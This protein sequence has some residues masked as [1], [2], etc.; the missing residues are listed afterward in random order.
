MAGPY[1]HAAGCAAVVP[2][3]AGAVVVAA[4]GRRMWRCEGC[5]GALA[6]V[7]ASAAALSTHPPHVFLLFLFVCC[8]ARASLPGGSFLDACTYVH[9]ACASG[10]QVVAAIVAVCRIPHAG[11]PLV[12]F[13]SHP[14]PK[15]ILLP[16]GLRRLACS[17]QPLRGLLSQQCTGANDA[18]SPST[19]S[20][21]PATLLQTLSF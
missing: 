15:H 12:V 19:P 16:H 4:A 2:G 13:C 6:G 17:L 18:A 20:E 1:A 7:C 3:P 14:R 10:A 21:P 9:A 5:V 11:P 8:A